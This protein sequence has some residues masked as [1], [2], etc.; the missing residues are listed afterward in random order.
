MRTITI[1]AGTPH[2]SISTV[3]NRPHQHLVPSQPSFHQEP[4]G[5]QYAKLQR[6]VFAS[7]AF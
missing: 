4:V 6:F 3:A 7:I 1:D 2:S 5:A